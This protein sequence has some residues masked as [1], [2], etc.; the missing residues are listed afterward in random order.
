MIGFL[1]FLLKRASLK[2]LLLKSFSQRASLK[3]PE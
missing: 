3:D 2:E 1:L